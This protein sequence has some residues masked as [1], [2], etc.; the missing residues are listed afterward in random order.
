MIDWITVFRLDTL[1]PLVR[2]RFSLF[3]IYFLIFT[4]TSWRIF[5][6]ERLNAFASWKIVTKEGCLWPHSKSEM[7][8][9]SRLL[10][11]AS[12]SWE[13]RC[14]FLSSLITSPNASSIVKVASLQRTFNR[15][16][17]DILL[18]IDNDMYNKN[19]C[20]LKFLKR[21]RGFLF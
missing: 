8:L 5:D 2:S 4:S 10:T 7:K 3:P 16:E 18:T 6:A 15:I 17:R 9:L 20:C 21:E 13:I 19:N 11:S 12:F 14:S 1:P